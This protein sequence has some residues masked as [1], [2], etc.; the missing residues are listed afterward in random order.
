MKTDPQRSVAVNVPVFA[1][2]VEAS[3]EM[4]TFPGHEMAGGVLSWM[5]INCVPD[6]MLLQASFAYQVRT[7]V[8]VPAHP[9][10]PKTLSEKVT[11]I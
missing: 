11:T 5:V 3:Q 4:V 1:G 7:M 10:S 9:V 8:P 6:A 2:S